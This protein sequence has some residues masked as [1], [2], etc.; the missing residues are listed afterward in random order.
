MKQII[1]QAVYMMLLTKHS[2]LTFS[3]EVI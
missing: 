2:P 1:F 3:L